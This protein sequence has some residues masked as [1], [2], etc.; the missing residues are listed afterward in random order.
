MRTHTHTHHVPSI[1]LLHAL[2]IRMH[3][4]S[5][6]SSSSENIDNELPNSALLDDNESDIC[7]FGAYF[8]LVQ[9][10]YQSL[11]RWIYVVS[12]AHLFCWNILC[13]RHSNALPPTHEYMRGRLR[14]RQSELWVV[15]TLFSFKIKHLMQAI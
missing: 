4:S 14:V 3:T 9:R 13:F 6:I 12:N 5:A 8:E 2:L 1:Q 7:R 10:I 11:V 15:I